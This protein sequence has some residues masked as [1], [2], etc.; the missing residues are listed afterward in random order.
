MGAIG[1]DQA[2]YKNYG[3]DDRNTRD[4]ARD[5]GGFEG[6][7]GKNQ[8]PP[9]PPDFIGAAREQGAQNIAL[10]RVNAAL[11]N[12]NVINPLGSRTVKFD[13]DQA[14]I[15]QSFAPGIQG[16]ID[17]GLLPS[18]AENFSKPFGY[19]SASDLQNKTEQALFSRLEPKFQNDEDALRTRLANQ[20]IAIGSEAYNKDMDAFNRSKNDARQQAVLGGMQAAPQALQQESFIRSAPLNALLALMSGQPVQGFNPSGNAK[21]GNFEGATAQAGDYA[22]DL[23][24]QQQAQAAQN[25]GLLGSAGIAA[26][27]MFSDR[28]LKSN[29]V[30]LGEDPRGWG[31][32]E[33][34]IFGERQT[35]VMADEVEKVIPEAVSTHE[36]GYKMVHYGMLYEGA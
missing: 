12:P 3:G 29:I 19:E 28:R 36:S 16:A 6:A 9:P 30:K 20:G 1:V 18:I 10:A 25:R 35:G 7:M 27:S 17:R 11:N 32:Y 22:T 8:E 21:A 5:P 2:A 4:I 26:A 14:T 33:Y 24:N 34:D 13:G 31:V 15:N 23:W